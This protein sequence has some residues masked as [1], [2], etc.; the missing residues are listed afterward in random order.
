MVNFAVTAA[1]GT[2]LWLAYLLQEQPTTG[3]VLEDWQA[4]HAVSKGLKCFARNAPRTRHPNTGEV[5]LTK[6]SCCSAWCSL[7]CGDLKYSLCDG[8]ISGYLTIKWW[9]WLL[10]NDWYRSAIMRLPWRY[11]SSCSGAC[12]RQAVCFHTRQRQTLQL[13]FVLD[14]GRKLHNWHFFWKY[15]SSGTIVHPGWGRW[16]SGTFAPIFVNSAHRQFLQDGS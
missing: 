9:P 6:A 11:L 3:V 7:R 10:Q 5:D 2:A 4:I 1:A 12:S 16:K 15:N 13:L 14:T 8:R